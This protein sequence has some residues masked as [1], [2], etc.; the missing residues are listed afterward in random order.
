MGNDFS[1]A[2]RYPSFTPPEA[3]GNSY[4]PWI[5]NLII[6]AY[7]HR[8]TMKSYNIEVKEKSA[9]IALPYVVSASVICGGHLKRLVSIGQKLKRLSTK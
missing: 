2:S 8:M 4:F 6:G 5:F 3:K 7:K 9:S 1:D